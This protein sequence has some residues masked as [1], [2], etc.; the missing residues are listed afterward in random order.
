[1]AIFGAPKSYG[2]DALDASRCALRMI[3]ERAKLNQTSR[4]KIEVGIGVATGSAVAG[5]MGSADHMSY[6]V[7]GERVNLGARLCSQ[8]GRGE[9][10]IDQTTCE[11]LGDLATVTPMPDLKLK[12]FSNPMK[13]C[14][15]TALAPKPATK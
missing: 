9:V 10:V 2:N 3:E 14:K 5:C 13:A 15:L 7:L 11:R 12:G 8:A 4:H 1:M 6:T